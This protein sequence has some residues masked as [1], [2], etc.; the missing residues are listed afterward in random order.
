MILSKLYRDQEVLYQRKQ[1][2]ETLKVFGI[3]AKYYPVNRDEG[4]NVY[5]FYNDMKDNELSFSKPIL[6]RIVFEEVP[7]IRTLKSLGWYI[8]DES[9]PYLAYI[10]TEYLDYD[11]NKP[12]IP[13]VDDKIELL[14]NTVINIRSKRIYQIKD[15][16]SLGYPNTI[17]HIAKLAPYR[18][19]LIIEEGD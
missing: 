6:I 10:P 7:Q 2:Q 3:L 1:F 11:T 8:D 4:S 16:R 14:D 18:E 19:N 13:Q 17:Y 5:D 15:M 9:L 12:L